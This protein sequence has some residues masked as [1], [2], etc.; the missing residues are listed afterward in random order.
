[1]AHRRR[2][3]AVKQAL[4]RALY[5]A[6]FLLYHTSSCVSQNSVMEQLNDVNTCNIAYLVV[7]ITEA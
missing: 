3:E 6:I 7:C 1:M 4:N 2:L 5:I